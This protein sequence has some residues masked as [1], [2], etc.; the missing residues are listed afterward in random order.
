MCRPFQHSEISKHVEPKI[1]SDLTSE[2]P[3]VELTPEDKVQI[4]A[5][6]DK[7]DAALVDKPI[8]AS[9]YDENWRKDLREKALSAQKHGEVTYGA[10]AYAAPIFEDLRLCPKC[11][12]SRLEEGARILLPKLSNGERKHLIER[13]CESNPTSAE[14]ELLL[15]RGFA[16]EFGVN[17]I[18]GPTGDS[19][20][21]RPEFWVS[22]EGKSIA[23]EA[24]GLLDSRRVRELNQSSRRLGLNYWISTDPNVVDP[25]HVRNAL[26]TKI[27]KSVRHSPCIIVLTLYG[28]FD[29]LAGIDLARQIAMIPSQF[30]I[31]PKAYPLA[32][33]LVMSTTRFIQ[34]V[35]FNSSLV[36]KIG[37]SNETRERIRRALQNSF[38]PRNDGVFLHEQMT[39]QDHN[40]AVNKMHAGKK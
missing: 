30:K 10:M 24:K 12:Q 20:S 15:A 26:A 8:L 13:M 14:E 3:F 22:V 37:I 7:C 27:L 40:V 11:Y 9:I 39:D 19:S 33:A 21:P 17:A 23:I 25:N 6:F 16:L 38:Y 2:V 4:K 32:V 35:W 29:F 31:P 34:G 18:R 36:E 28:P 5:N 1:Q